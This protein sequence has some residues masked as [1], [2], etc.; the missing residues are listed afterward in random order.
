[1]N[2]FLTSSKA[3]YT[4]YFG[5][6]GTYV[7]RE[8]EAPIGY[9]M[10]GE[11]SGYTTNK[12]TEKLQ[13]G[14]AL[15]IDVITEEI[16]GDEYTYHKYYLDGK[17]ITTKILQAE[18]MPDP[19]N[20][21]Y[22]LDTGTALVADDNPEIPELTSNA[23]CTDTMS[24]YAGSAHRTIN[25]TDEIRVHTVSRVNAWYKVTSKLYNKTKREFVEVNWK[26]IDNHSQASTKGKEFATTFH[27]GESDITAGNDFIFKVGGSIDLTDDMKGDTFVFVNYLLVAEGT[28][29]PGN[30]ADKIIWPSNYNKALDDASAEEKAEIRLGDKSSLNDTNEMIYI[31]DGIATSLVNTQTSRKAATGESIAYAG[32]Y[33]DSTCTKGHGT[34]MQSF[35][36]TIS[37]NN[38]EEGK[39]YKIKA[40]LMD[41]TNGTPAPAVDAQ[42]RKIETEKPEKAVANGSGTWEVTFNF[43]T[44]VCEGRKYVSYV[45]VYDN[46]HLVLEHKKA[47]DKQESFMIPKITTKLRCTDSTSST[48]PLAETMN[49]ED[50][51]T[52]QNLIPNANYKVETVVMDLETG[53][54]LVDAKGNKA[55]IKSGQTFTASAGNGTHKVNF[56]IA[57]VKTD[58]NKIVTSSL[59][60]KTIVVYQYIYIEKNSN[61]SNQWVLVAEHADMDDKDQSMPISNSGPLYL[62]L[63]K[64]NAG[65]DTY[66]NADLSNAG[67]E[68]AFY[69]G[70]KFN[71]AMDATRKGSLTATFTFKTALANDSAL[72]SVPYRNAALRDGINARFGIDCY[73][74]VDEAGNFIYEKDGN[75]NQ[76]FQN[77]FLTSDRAAYTK[78]FGQAGTYVVR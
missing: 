45:E 49:F 37:Y 69:K 50:T 16:D 42:N 59:A 48:A 36:D 65:G 47:D 20:P 55:L 63:Y 17:E 60:G 64:R 10:T 21:V 33:T 26:K 73:P 74:K 28:S 3:E 29:D 68:I 24:Q 31:Y 61:G 78:Y 1:M 19:D 13:D 8:I 22:G 41:I 53:R 7:I 58:S 11:M 4:K 52:Y 5:N 9:T 62:Y 72:G 46:D 38:L 66:E 76:L 67:F 18:N 54:E 32:M 6:R 27:T 34:I 23:L 30:D 2:D 35:T 14:L 51:I 75:G 71:S 56:S 44:T 25:L 15:S 43:D 57:G 70:Q 77:D 39:N 40:W 12:K